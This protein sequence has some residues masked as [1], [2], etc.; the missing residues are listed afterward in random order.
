[1][2][3]PLSII[4]NQK[5]GFHA[6]QNDRV[7]EEIMTIFTEYDFEIQVFELNSQ[8]SLDQLMQQVL[9]RHQ[10][11]DAA[12]VVVAAGG[13][14]TL[15]AV[16]SHLLHTNIC[17]GILPLGTFN[18]VARV[19][20]IPLDLLEA[21]RVVVRGEVK[22]IH[23]AQLNNHIYLN[24][25]SLGL[26]PLFIEKREYYNRLF[27]RFPLHAYT[28]ALDVLLRRHR[29]LKLEVVVDGEKYPVKTPLVFFGNNHLQL[30]EMNLKIA[31]VVQFGKIAGVI[32]AK[33]D[34]LTLM[35][36]LFQLLKGDIEKANDIYSFAADQVTV[37]ARKGK[38]L[39]VALD[40]ELI[41]EQ[42]PL[43]FSVN[44]HALA[45]M[46]PQDATPSL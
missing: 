26:Y 40:G 24:N 46:V 35:K 19:L 23:V 9:I 20:N 12:G 10:N 27:G 1:M 30:Q 44:R 21:A 33:S 11:A 3:K 18:Y 25:A 36:L 38:K 34:K 39:H 45:V 8:V 41:E 22:K 14:G 32:V 4:Y 16:A 28:S 37:Y 6:T 43:H 15:N 42:S 7:Y 31:H 5:S 2:L 29:E 13:D 17:M